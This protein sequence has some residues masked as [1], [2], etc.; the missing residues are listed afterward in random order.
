[1]KKKILVSIILLLMASIMFNACGPSIDLN[2]LIARWEVETGGEGSPGPKQIIIFRDN[3]TAEFIWKAS[4]A[5][6][7]SVSGNIL[8]YSI[9]NETRS[10]SIAIND[11]EMCIG[12]FVSIDADKDTLV[13]RWRYSESIENDT[14]KSYYTDD[15]NFKEDGTFENKYVSYSS[16]TSNSKE[17]EQT[18][19]GRW[20]YD[21]AAGTI[22]TFI[23]NSE[24]GMEPSDEIVEKTYQIYMLG[25]GFCGLFK[26]PKAED[27]GDLNL[28]EY[29]KKYYIYKKKN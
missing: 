27:L 16:G 22:K 8:T 28:K 26:E 12:A 15:Y 13:G 20:E 24:Y 9:E 10:Y 17:S 7:Y 1:M 25:D 19:N 3:G 5:G 2:K 6:K 29:I 23:K 11:D 21:S 4:G 14:E 18:I